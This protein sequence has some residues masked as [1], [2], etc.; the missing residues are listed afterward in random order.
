MRFAAFDI[1]TTSLEGSYG[2]LLCA[3]FKFFDEDEVRTI[4]APKLKDEAKAL[5]EIAKT[6]EEAHVLVGWNSKHFDWRFLEQ[7]AIV[8]GTPSLPA[9]LHL[10]LI[11]HH[12]HYF[13]SRGHSLDGVAKDLKLSAQKYDVPASAW[14]A[15]ADGDRNALDE[16]VKHCEQDVIITEE[17]HWK[18]APYIRNI[19]R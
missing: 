5:R 3:C 7:R 1:E 14:L 17:A 2:R 10:D 11:H 9:K 16:I 6:V 18:L 4:V 13:R 15:A 12:R 8:L 19:S